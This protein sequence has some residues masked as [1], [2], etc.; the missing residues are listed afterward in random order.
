[1]Y[2]GLP[3]TTERLSLTIYNFFANTVHVFTHFNCL[4]INVAKRRYSTRRAVHAVA[5]KR[6]EKKTNTKTLLS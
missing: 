2:S 3:G 6:T 4:L 5:L 1:M